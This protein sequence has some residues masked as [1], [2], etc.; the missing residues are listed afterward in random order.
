[1]TSGATESKT[2][3]TL[4][5]TAGIIGGITAILVSLASLADATGAF[6]GLFPVRTEAKDIATFNN[7]QVLEH[8]TYTVKDNSTDLT[9]KIREVNAKGNLV[10]ASLSTDPNYEKYT[11]I[12]NGQ[13]R[14]FVAGENQYVITVND[15]ADVAIGTDTATITIRR[16]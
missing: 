15:L 2:I 8:G 9:L 10:E 12:P 6:K 16:K 3:S 11:E 4:K 13:E 1:M 7:R 14:Y 5:R